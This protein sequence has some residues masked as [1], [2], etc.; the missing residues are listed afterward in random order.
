MASLFPDIENIQRLTVPPTAGEEYLVRFLQKELGDDCEIFFNSYLDGD[1]PDIIILKKD[2]G[3]VVIEIKD[4]D[5]AHYRIDGENKWL[6]QDAVLRSPQQQAFRYKDNL[7]NLHLPVLGLKELVN[8]NFYNVI[9]VFVYFHGASKE[10]LARLYERALF[11]VNEKILHLNASRLDIGQVS[12]DKQMNHWERKRSQISRDI[13][14]AWTQDVLAKKV[15]K[16]TGLGRNILFS[17]D[18]YQDFK[19]RLAPPVHT[20]RQGI[21][22]NF[23]SRQLLSTLS[24]AGFSKVKGVA[25]CGKTSVL[26]QRAVNAHLRHQGQVLILTYNITL[27]HFIRDTI[28]R[29]QGGCSNA[30]E[31]IHYHGF[32]NAKINEHGIDINSKRNE[33]PVERRG[34]PYE[35]YQLLTMFEGVDAEKFKT[36]LIDEVQDYEPEW[37]KILRDNF[38]AKDGEMAL[39]GDQ[40]QNI[41]ERADNQRETSVVQGFGRWLKLNRSYRSDPDALLVDVFRRFQEQYLVGK[42]ADSEVFE[43]GYQQGAMNFDL[44]AYESY[45]TVYRAEA[46]LERIQAYI[47]TRNL[48]PND[49]AIVSAQVK[50]LFE[51]NELLKQIEKTKVMFEESEELVEIER[52]KR[53][54]PQRYREEVEKIRR[55]KKTF[56]MQNSGLIKISTIHSFKGHEAETVFC[57]LTADDTAE[58]VYTGITRTQKNLVV[59]DHE[60]SK[61]GAFFRSQIQ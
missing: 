7:F 10:N 3:A 19:R 58:M 27:R 9:S 51:L 25:G 21:P 59:F 43:T 20:V 4:W 11:E 54:E 6:C 12:Y 57:I 49:I 35:I 60:T 28:S 23:D 61:F 14:M 36:I 45:G 55:R 18:I 41:Y 44:V 15:K 8:R 22:I 56:F 34:D 32:I 46:V 13:N 53:F 16:V 50:Y 48:Q 39:F 5:L 52:F 31:I 24:K 17:D 40:S 33:L 1:R 29:M 26:A 38:L 42:Y 2:C 37:I 47:R 30:Y